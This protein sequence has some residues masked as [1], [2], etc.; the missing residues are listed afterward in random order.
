MNTGQRRKANYGWADAEEELADG[1]HPEVVA[2]RLGEPVSYV[3][4]VAEQQ[5]WPVSYEPI[6]PEHIVDAFLRSDA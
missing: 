1:I 5:G 2:A 4:E 6:R 3:I